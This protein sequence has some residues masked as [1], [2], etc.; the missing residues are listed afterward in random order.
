M[1]LI[2]LALAVAA[3]A[4]SPLVPHTS[5]AIPPEQAWPSRFDGKPL[6]RLP[7]APSDRFFTR[8]FPG[9]VARFSDGQRQIVLRQVTQATRKLHPA[10]DC[11]RAIGYETSETSL[12]K[13]P[14][15]QPRACFTARRSDKALTICEE[16]RDAKG[17]SYPEVSAWYWPALMGQS[18]GPWVAATLVEAKQE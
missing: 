3:A 5:S 16:I 4:L 17:V 2:L 18:T 9:H 6:T 13:S 10:R 11:F 15:G 1:R 12:Q 8:D 14:D 7:A